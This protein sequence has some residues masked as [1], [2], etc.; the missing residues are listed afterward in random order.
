MSCSQNCKCRPAVIGFV[1]M[2][3]IMGSR[4]KNKATGKRVWDP[5]AGLAFEGLS[6]E[7]KQAQEDRQA[8]LDAALAD[9]DDSLAEG[10]GKWFQRRWTNAK[11]VWD[12]V[13]E[14][15]RAV[16]RKVKMIPTL[17]D[18]IFAGPAKR[19]K[20]L[21]N[22][23]NG[24]AYER[25]N[26]LVDVD[27]GTDDYFKT[28]TNVPPSMIE[29]RRKSGWGEIL[30]DSYGPF[31]NHLESEFGNM[32][33]KYPNV[34]FL[35]FAVGYNWM[36][37]NDIA[38]DR[39]KRKLDEFKA[40][41]LADN[42]NGVS[43][44]DIKFILVSHSMGG[45]AS[46]A[47]SELSKVDIEGALLGAMPTHGSPD[48]YKRFR[49]G[50]AGGA[51][52]VIGKNA[53]DMTAI[54]GFSQGGLQLLPNQIY[55]TADGSSQWLFYNTNKGQEGKDKPLLTEYGDK[56]YDF[57]K[58]FDSWYQM[59]MPELLAPELSPA[60]FT[61]S[62]RKQYINAYFKQIAASKKFNKD[63]DDHFYENTALIYSS[64]DEKKHKSYDRCTWQSNGEPEGDMKQW[65]THATENHALFFGDGTVWL[66]AGEE[67]LNNPTDD[68]ISG[69]NAPLAKTIAFTIGPAIAAGDSTVHVGAGKYITSALGEPGKIPVDEFSKD[70]QQFYNCGKVREKAVEE[71]QKWVENI[72]NKMEAG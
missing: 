34:K 26:E 19:K 51:K 18:Y 30:W 1:F 50:Q 7:G 53:A 35:S 67:P 37:G 49:T 14:K 42:P 66:G 2:P 11:Q 48:S 21:V 43:K 29:R 57:Y 44:Q 61:E 28:F 16:R 17:T 71:L 65:V 70:H 68:G 45:L 59:V 24:P 31:L 54:L 4:L 41:I 58:R 12:Y 47:A 3:G 38:G 27:E 33:C 40:L 13:K 39:I 20:M 60:Q 62:E 32:K 52:L 46:R 55:K 72:H 22:D 63:L 9:D 10:I 15:G 23:C 36:Q 6:G 69:R 8:E 56:I 5:S 64:S 25:D